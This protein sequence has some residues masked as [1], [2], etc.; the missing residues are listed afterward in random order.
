ML[1]ENK[2]LKFFAKRDGIILLILWGVILTG[3]IILLFVLGSVSFDKSRSNEDAYQRVNKDLTGRIHD[4]E[5]R[6]KE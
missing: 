4:L 1:S 2:K 3:A 5:Q 6:I